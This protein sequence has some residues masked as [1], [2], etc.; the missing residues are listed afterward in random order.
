M[1]V[2]DK[3]AHR[4]D[5]KRSE[6]LP[7]PKKTLKDC[8]F[9]VKDVSR[10][11]LP[12]TSASQVGHD[13]SKQPLKRKL[14]GA[15]DTKDLSDDSCSEKNSNLNDQSA[16]GNITMRPKISNIYTALSSKFRVLK[17]ENLHCDYYP[18]FFSKKE[19][20]DLFRDCEESLEYFTGELATVKLYGKNIPIPRKQVR[21]T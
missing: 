1:E 3:D 7:L 12:H 9:I 10:G 19:A 5:G 14:E 13:R 17:A 16:D 2:V 4:V 11:N 8:G 18:N 6:G 21:L 20:D 15:D